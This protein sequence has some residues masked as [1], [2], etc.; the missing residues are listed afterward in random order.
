MQNLGISGL[1]TDDDRVTAI[2]AARSS[3]VNSQVG[4]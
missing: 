3:S 2:R 1:H 4:K